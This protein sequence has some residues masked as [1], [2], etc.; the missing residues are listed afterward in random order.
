MKAIASEPN[1]F[2]LYHNDND[3]ILSVECGTSAVYDLQ[4]KLNEQEV[5]EYKAIGD[6]YIHGLALRINSS[7]ENY[8]SRRI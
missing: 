6:E 2:I 3:F 8:E 4:I 5:I 1:L 7:P